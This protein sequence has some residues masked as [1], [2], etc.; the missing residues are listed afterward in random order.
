MR[1][2]GIQVYKYIQYCASVYLLFF[3]GLQGAKTL[4]KDGKTV[5]LTYHFVLDNDAIFP[6]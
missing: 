1:L 4:A 6:D 5:Q 2:K 3:D